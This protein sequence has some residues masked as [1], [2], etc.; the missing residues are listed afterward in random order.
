MY[1]VAKQLPLETRGLSTRLLLGRTTVFT[2]SIACFSRKFYY[3]SPCTTIQLLHNSTF[4]I[5][6]P[7]LAV[8]HGNNS[9][10]SYLNWPRNLFFFLS[11]IFSPS[12]ILSLS[13]SLG[14]R[15]MVSFIQSLTQFCLNCFKLPRTFP[16]QSYLYCN[17]ITSLFSIITSILLADR[18]TCEILSLFW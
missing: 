8:G 10:D 7:D 16:V 12:L 9:H 4:F 13:F 6:V 17:L 14:L 3:L 1:R 5:G 15:E 11:L 2:F 18:L